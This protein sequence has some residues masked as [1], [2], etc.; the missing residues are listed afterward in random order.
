MRERVY[1]GRYMKWCATLILCVT[2][3]STTGQGHWDDRTLYT[4]LLHQTSARTANDIRVIERRSDGARILLMDDVPQSGVLW[5]VPDQFGNSICARLP[6]S[7]YPYAE[8]LQMGLA[9]LNRNPVRILLLGQG[10][11]V[12]AMQMAMRFPQA[13]IDIVEL[14]PLIS[15]I[16]ASKELFPGLRCAAKRRIS[17]TLHVEDARGFMARAQGTWDLIIIDVFQGLSVPSFFQSGSFA[18]SLRR[19]MRVDGVAVMNVISF[20]G[21]DLITRDNWVART[22]VATVRSVLPSVC[23]FVVPDDSS[24]AAMT[25]TNNKEDL[26]EGRLRNVIIIASRASVTSEEDACRRTTSLR[27]P[28]IVQKMMIDGPLPW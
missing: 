3:S 2:W 13:H 15:E 26:D 1:H 20:V 14:D 17:T 23:S 12:V 16:A 21:R 27:D 19:A 24:A 5:N 25:S 4:T 22:H 11:G 28:V 18:Q 6:V 10:A 8:A 9:F 7:I